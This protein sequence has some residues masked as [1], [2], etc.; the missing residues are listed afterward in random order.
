MEKPVLRECGSP[1]WG[2]IARVLHDTTKTLMPTCKFAVSVPDQ[3]TDTMTGERP[4]LQ[5][6]N[7]GSKSVGRQKVSSV[8]TMTANKEN[9]NKGKNNNNGGRPSSL[10]G[11]PA[12]GAQMERM[13]WGNTIIA[14]AAILGLWWL[15]WRL[16][17]TFL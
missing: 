3:R 13:L 2:V 9:K 11:G 10:S 15:Q 5:Q 17:S 14:A 4:S 7:N 8:G 12:N 6:S 16:E 1:A